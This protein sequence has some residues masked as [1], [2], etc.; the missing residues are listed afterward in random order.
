VL[1]NKARLAIGKNHNPIISFS[2][3]PSFSSQTHLG[4]LFPTPASM[5]DASGSRLNLG[6]SVEKRGRGR[7]RGSKNKASTDAAVASSSTLVKR[8]PGCLVG[9]KNKPKV[10]FAA[11]GPSA[12]S[13]NVSSPSPRLFSFFCIAGPQYR[14]IQ[15]L[16][17][18]FT[19]FMDGQELREAVL[20]EHSG[21]GTPYEVKVWYDGAGEQYF[22]GGWSQF[23]EDHDLHQVFFMTFDFHVGTSKFDVKIYDCIQCQ[24][25]YE[26]KVH[27]H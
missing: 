18:N 15:S 7:P 17:L 12:P 21:G 27:F 23:A 13:A 6:A 11:P 1:I 16:P 4:F 14:E 5:A 19:K 26:A 10:P 20:R 2:A 25:E 9:S 22:K 3:A 24:K 8:R